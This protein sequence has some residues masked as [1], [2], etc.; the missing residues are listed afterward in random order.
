MNKPQHEK[1]TP[2]VTTHLGGGKFLSFRSNIFEHAGIEIHGI[3]PHAHGLAGFRHLLHLL[4]DKIRVLDVAL[5]LLKDL[6]T[7]VVL[8]IVH[9]LLQE[10]G[11]TE[12]L[13]GTRPVCPVFGE[14]W[15]MKGKI[16]KL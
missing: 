15:G 9:Q 8:V 12:D 11:V 4:R 6:R 3:H 5:Q 14:L 2:N 10:V 16:S 7:D 1:R 13:L